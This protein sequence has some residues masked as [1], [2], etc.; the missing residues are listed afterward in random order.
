MAEE[1]PSDLRTL[2]GSV[3]R[4]GRL[5]W[6]GRAPKRRA[7]IE[8]L[9]E[10]QVEV[11][12]G[13]EGEHHARSGKGKRQVTLIQAEHLPVL[14]KLLDREE[15]LPEELRRN[16]AVSGIN[17]LGLRSERFSIGEVVRHRFH[18]FRGVIYDVDPTFSNTEESEVL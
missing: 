1:Q 14:A 11:G 10:V 6:I 12:T 16:L 5:E 9:A 18:P 13:L 4:Q 17:L 15:V 8:S 3:P 7:A 2:L